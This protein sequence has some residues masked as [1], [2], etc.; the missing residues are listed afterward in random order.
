MSNTIPPGGVDPRHSP[1][2]REAIRDA[3]KVDALVSIARSLERIAFSLER[4]S[5]QQAAAATDEAHED[6]WGKGR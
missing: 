6:T 2:R 5:G 4:I 3:A 1:Q